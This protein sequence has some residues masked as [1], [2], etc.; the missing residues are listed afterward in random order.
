MKRL[1]NMKIGDRLAIGFAIILALSIVSTG[2]GIWRMQVVSKVTRAMVDE[3]VRKERLISSL[4]TNLRGGILR[5]IAILRSTDQMLNAFF[6]NEDLIAKKDAIALQKQIGPLLVSDEEKQLYK[7]VLEQQV[8]Y[9]KINFHLMEL[10]SNGDAEEG[11]QIL[12]QEFVPASKRYQATLQ[13][14]L[15][16]EQAEIDKTS[17]QI[18][19][20]AAQ[21]RILLLIVEVAALLFGVSCAWLLTRSIV[22]PLR[23]AV[24]IS[25]KVADG[26]LTTEIQIKRTDEVGQLLM[27]LQGMNTNL[28]NIVNNV[29]TGTVTIATASREIAAG[30]MDLSSRTESQASALEETASAMEELIS[31]VRS[32]ADNA[33]EASELA[34]S[35][36]S[37]A[38]EGGNAV[39]NM[40]QTM[41]EINASSKKI[42][43]IISVIDGI[44]FQT[45]ILAL[46]A[47]VEAARAG[48]QGRGF[49]VVASEVRSLA[50]RSAAAAKEI[51]ALIDDS[52][53]RVSN[54]SMQVE[55][56]GA[57]MANVVSSV[58]RV[59][60][61]VHEIS[62]ASQ[63]QA[64]GI[65]QVN[66]TVTQLDHVTQQN[67]A[68]V[69]EA[70]SAADAMQQQA[71]NLAK[72]VS[73]FI[74]DS[75]APVA[76]S[77]VAAS[78]MA[79]KASPASPA[80]SAPK[81]G[82]SHRRLLRA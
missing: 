54:G 56:A 29:R 75:S 30:N 76:D 27:S 1:S 17:L 38:I 5:T 63:E 79:T 6:L 8:N 42:V 68:L 80:L 71:A 4:N 59:T 21:S 19:V 36:S 14:L 82:A 32:N 16:W 81:N 23:Q 7:Q 41:G 13:K 43:D 26:D 55:R 53:K 48:E 24:E 77:N 70:A 47:A 2:I 39:D 37:I 45:N 15:E 66:D 12:V 72:L 20:I 69:E 49:A 60:S 9:A 11:N 46:N 3:S 52:V 10:K 18:D 22:W 31:T 25:R 34:S 61:I 57:T 33:R 64:E 74:T 67:A 35:A 58:K 62:E 78:H 28:R 65:E 40:V 44:A 51:K 50:Q 73:V